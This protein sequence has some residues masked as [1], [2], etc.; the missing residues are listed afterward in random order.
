[1][2]KDVTLPEN[3]SALISSLERLS[4]EQTRIDPTVLFS[5]EERKNLNFEILFVAL[6]ATSVLAVPD[7]RTVVDPLADMSA[8]G[9]II[10]TTVR[11]IGL[12]NEW[13]NTDV[14]LN[15]TLSFVWILSYFGIA[16]VVL[17]LSQWLVPEPSVR[18]YLLY[19]LFTAILSFSVVILY[20]S[21]FKDM[22]LWSAVISYNRYAKREDPHERI[23]SLELANLLLHYSSNEY[24]QRHYAIAKIRHHWKP[25]ST[26]RPSR[27]LLTV[28]VIGL[29]F[30]FVIGAILIGIP[31]WFITDV[32]LLNSAIIHGILAFASLFISS[33]L[34][35]FYVRYGTSSYDDTPNLIPTFIIITFIIYLHAGFPLSL[36]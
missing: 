25:G 23:Y 5:K 35:F 29:L 21:V 32:N 30:T 13:V 24:D 17:A 28:T 8:I 34:T 36:V 4:A 16:Y 7:T 19:S 3:T 11:R 9:L 20:E 26:V 14:I 6:I 27:L 22:F 10:L 12:D 2:K 31:F 18:T 1:M 15:K 33:L